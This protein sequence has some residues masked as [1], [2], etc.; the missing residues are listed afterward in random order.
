MPSAKPDDGRS[1]SEGLYLYG[2]VAADA[3]SSYGPIGLS[4]SADEVFT[5]PQNNLSA[6]VSNTE[7]KVPLPVPDNI[8]AHTRVLEAIMKQTTVVPAK[9]GMVFASRAALLKLMRQNAVGLGEMLRML[10]NKVEL[11]LQVAW[12]KEVLQAMITAMADSDAE[13]AELKR[14][15]GKGNG[16]KIALHLGELVQ[17]KVQGKTDR[18]CQLLL[19]PLMQ[20]ADDTRHKDVRTDRMVMNEA[21]LVDRERESQFDAIVEELAEQHGDQLEFNYSGP[22]PPFS[23]VAVKIDRV[24]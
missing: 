6:V 3:P 21:F 8:L 11:G 15:A 18:L 23:F 4:G 1:T 7:V 20:A 12:R 16:F 10:A 22:W 2:F 19:S 13:I 17:T 5:V 24:E 9:F 14:E